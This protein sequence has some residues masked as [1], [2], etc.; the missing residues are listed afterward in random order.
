MSPRPPLDGLYLV[1][2]LTVAAQFEVIQLADL[3]SVEFEK[4]YAMSLQGVQRI[5]GRFTIEIRQIV[6][7]GHRR[8]LFS[9]NKL[10]VS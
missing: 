7:K 2:I 9:Q 6:K 8:A 5:R 1:E 3:S 10:L 4:R